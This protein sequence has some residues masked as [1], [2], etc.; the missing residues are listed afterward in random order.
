MEIKI[1][2]ADETTHLRQL[3]L[4]QHQK[5]EELIYPGDYDDDTLHFGAFVNSELV[6]IA[7]IYKEKL[8]DNEEPEAWR[9]RGMA[10]IETVRG[11]GYGKDLMNECLEHIKKHHG[12]ILWCNARISAEKFYEKFGMKRK[13]EIFYPG[14]LGPH[15]VM[16]KETG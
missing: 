4:R 15:V 14:D 11:K 7:S 2:I 3:T 16:W 5:E 8:K 6:G 9:L 10:T 1:I 13:G 12:K